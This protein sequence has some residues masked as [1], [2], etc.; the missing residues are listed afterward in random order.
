MSDKSNSLSDQDR[1]LISQ[2]DIE[3]KKYEFES[4][5]PA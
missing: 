3:F 4:Q 5:T 1:E 2:I